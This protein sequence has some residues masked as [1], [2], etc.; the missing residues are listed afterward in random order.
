M[1]DDNRIK[2]E[3]RN[4]VEAWLNVICE[5]LNAGV[6]WTP[7]FR[8]CFQIADNLGLIENVS[9]KFSYYFPEDEDID[10]LYPFVSKI[11]K[12]QEG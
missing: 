9:G 7:L 8:S 2:D 6:D 10:Y 4:L 12:K 3:K 5:R 11:M 1:Y